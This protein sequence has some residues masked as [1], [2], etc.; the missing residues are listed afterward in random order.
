MKGTPKNSGALSKGTT[1]RTKRTKRNPTADGADATD[2]GIHEIIIR[3]IR[4][5]RGQFPLEAYSDSHG[6]S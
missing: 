1:K 4:V 5:I 6:R 2:Q 3:D